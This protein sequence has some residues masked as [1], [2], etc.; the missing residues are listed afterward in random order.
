MEP[1]S[2]SKTA[3]R[4]FWAWE[5]GKEERWLE[6][7]ARQGWRLVS[8]GIVYR[9]VRDTPAEVRYRLDWRPGTNA[10]LKE[11]F[12]LCRDS[13]WQHVCSF[14]SWYYFRASDPAAP[15]LYTDRASLAGRYKR[16]IGFL[17]LIS[18][19][20]LMGLVNTLTGGG[21]PAR[22]RVALIA[23]QAALTLLVAYAIIRLALHIR[24]LKSG[25]AH[26]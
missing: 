14:G 21:P 20:N 2:A 9:F 6:E 15:E 26:S 12:D 23:S 16:L 3:W 24:Q 22:L 8:G 13:G 18:L 7:M 1:N 17:A 25:P 11:Y 5:D 4:W 19:P 10:A